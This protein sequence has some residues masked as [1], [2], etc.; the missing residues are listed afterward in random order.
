LAGAVSKH[1][2]HEDIGIQNRALPGIPLLLANRPA[3]FSDERETTS[4]G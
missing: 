2:P 3:A 4:I 1:G